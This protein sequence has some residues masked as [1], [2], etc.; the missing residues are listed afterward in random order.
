MTRLIR[1]SDVEEAHER[2]AAALELPFG[3][4]VTPLA[5]DTARR[6]GLALAPARDGRATAIFGNWKAHGSAASARALA[7]AI[8]AGLRGTAIP[9]GREI[10]VFPPFPHIPIVAAALAGSPVALG[11]Q[12]VSALPPGAATGAVPAE[13]L[14][15]L[16]LRWVIVGHSERR[17]LFGDTDEIVSKKLR[18]AIEAGLCAVLCVG[19]TLDERDA[20]RT[21]AVLRRQFLS[22]L[23]RIE[24][25]E[26]ARL[27][28]AYEP[29]WAI[30]TGLQ[31]LPSEA[32]REMSALRDHAARKYGDEVARAMR[33]V[34]GGS[35]APSNAARFFAL[36]SCDGVLVGGAS[37]KA[38]EFLTVCGAEW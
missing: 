15:D 10:A 19:E 38:P 37:L 25:A 34:Y 32:E 13:M 26:A 8:A 5:R 30:G 4:I 29:V 35:V 6:L 3:A 17:R 27:V 21:H 31:P 14:A 20:A 16:G 33:V 1:V 28:V 22:A 11:A 2:G 24:A 9:A 36:P 12:D 23:E 7:E 18:R